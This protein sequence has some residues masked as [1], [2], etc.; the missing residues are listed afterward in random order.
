MLVATD[1]NGTLDAAPG[2]LGPLLRALRAAGHSVVVLSGVG[3]DTPDDPKEAFDVK[4]QQMIGLDVSDC[5][6]SMV[7][8]SI[9]DGPDL[10]AAKATMAKTLGAALFIDNNA[11]NAKAAVAIG[12]PM[13]L[14]PQATRVKN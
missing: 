10:A 5:W 2:Q 6:D 4:V 9:K 14:V 1:L 3:H 8:F 11:D 13:A 12:I 7:V